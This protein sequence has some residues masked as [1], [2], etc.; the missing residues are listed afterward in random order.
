MLEQQR[1][2]PKSYIFR[3]YSELLKI[4]DSTVINVGFMLAIVRA[5]KMG[6]LIIVCHPDN[7]PVHSYSLLSIKEDEKRYQEATGDRETAILTVT[8]P[9]YI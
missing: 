9:L 5:E 4:K 7:Y 6:E 8:M 3:D 1:E 2:H